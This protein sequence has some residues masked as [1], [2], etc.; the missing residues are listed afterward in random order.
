M[1]NGKKKFLQECLDKSTELKDDYENLLKTR[2]EN[3]LKPQYTVE[4]KIEM[5][6]EY[7]TQNGASF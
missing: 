5:I 2:E 4:A 3:K 1:K 6:I 7:T